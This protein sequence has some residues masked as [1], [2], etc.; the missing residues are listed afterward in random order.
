M[1]ID[2][3]KTEINDYDVDAEDLRSR[4]EKAIA[5]LSTMEGAAHT[6][7][8]SADILDEQIT[9]WQEA[10]DKGFAGLDTGLSWWNSTFGG[11][12]PG[13]VYFVSGPPGCYKTTL[14]RQIAQY[15]A[16]STEKRVDLASLEQSSGQVLG[17]VVAHQSGTS[18]ARLNN[19][20]R[21]QDVDNI[22]NFKDRVSAWPLFVT[23]RTF[24]PTTLWSWARRAVSQGSQLLVL[25]YLQAISPEGRVDSEERRVSEASRTVTRIAKDLKTRFLVVSSESNEG[26]LRYSGQIEYDA[27][28]W[29]RMEL[30][31]ETVK[32]DIRKNR[33][34]ARPPAFEMRP[35]RGVLRWE[36]PIA[37][38]EE[39]RG[40]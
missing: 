1:E 36:G 27:W 22:R 16:G 12:L 18:I 9:F 30:T 20:P 26:R 23:D 6:E 11:M 34:G 39:D 19:H 2:Q 15:V 29:I 37:E 14:V 24:T 4:L 10:V 40:K 17:A 8:S 3:C 7:P 13:G 25:D 28:G 21:Q 5:D 38:P 33:F 35:E 32:V 31:G